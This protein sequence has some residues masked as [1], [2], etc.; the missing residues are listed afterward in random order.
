MNVTSAVSSTTG[1]PQVLPSFQEIPLGKIRESRTNPRR[2]FDEA[3]LA[4]LAVNIKQY[5]VLQPILVRPMSLGAPDLYE[6]EIGRASCRES[7]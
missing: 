5:G 1:A 7:V 2:Q 3:K 4:E 6:L